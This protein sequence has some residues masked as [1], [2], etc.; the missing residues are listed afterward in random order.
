MD[1]TAWDEPTVVQIAQKLG[2]VL[3]RGAIVVH[4]RVG[5]YDNV[6]PYRKL[7][8]YA[9]GTSWNLEHPVHVHVRT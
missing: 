2:R 6:A 3:P 7:H 8:T 4:N 9:V 1:D 5:G